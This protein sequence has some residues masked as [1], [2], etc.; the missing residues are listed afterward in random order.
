MTVNDIL[1]KSVA[2]ALLGT[3]PDSSTIQRCMMEAESALD[4]VLQ[5]V[6]AEA[7]VN[8]T[9]RPR[10]MKIVQAGEVGPGIFDVPATV[11]IEYLHLGQV[12]DA[13]LSANNLFGNVY[14][15]I[16]HYGDFLT[17]PA[18]PFG[19]YHV[20]GSANAGTAQIYARAP[21]TG[22]MSDVLGPLYLFAPYVPAKADINTAIDAELQNNILDKLALRLKG[23]AQ[24]KPA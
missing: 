14:S 7:A 20:L 21:F 24:T 8:P 6:C 13:D 10:V 5:E 17:Y 15:A 2:I 4:S 11:L 23:A 9:L 19:I 22:L 18:S 16:L 1:V 3:D 12:N